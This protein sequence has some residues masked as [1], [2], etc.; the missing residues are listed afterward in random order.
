MSKRKQHSP[1]F[2]AKVALEALKGEETVSELASRFGI[3]PTMIHQWKRALLE[4]ASGVFERGGRKKPEIDDEQVKDLHAKIGELAVANDFLSRKLKLGREVRRG[5]IEPDHP[6]LSIG[7]QCTLLSLSRSSF[8]YTPKGETE[9]NLA[10]MR[11][12]DEQF[13]ETPFFGVR[14]MTWH[15]RNEGHLVNEKRVRRLMRLM[16]LMP[17]YQKPNTSRPAKG[18]KVWPYLLKGL[19]VERPNQAWA[20]DITY[21]PMRRGFLYLV[22]IMDWHTRKVLAWRISN[23]LEADFCI[24]ALN[25]AVHKF[26]PPEVMNTDQGSQFTS[27]AWTDR[28]RRMGVRISM[29]GKGR[30]LDNIFVERLWRT[31]KYECVY[32][33]AWETG[34]QARAG[35]RDWMEFYNHRRPHSALGGK[36]PA[37]IYWQRIEQNQPDQQVQRVA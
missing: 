14:Q 2:K 15:L 24:E 19:R 37:V 35:V 8:Y 11:R 36:P 26:G 6:V 34:S 5:M 31:L 29:D 4:G 12:I 23:T 21:L 27:F 16:G 32:L 22:A 20:A 10:L 7:K 18:H 1:E 28:L 30:F 25:E 3:H 33:H 17:I 9:I 13:L